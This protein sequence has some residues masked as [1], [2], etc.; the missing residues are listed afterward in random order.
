MP[1][2]SNTN[3]SLPPFCT[4]DKNLAEEVKTQKVLQRIM[5]CDVIYPKD[6]GAS[7]ELK[8]LLSRIFVADPAKRLSLPGIQQH[9]WFLKVCGNNSSCTPEERCL[10]AR[11]SCSFVMKH[12]TRDDLRSVPALHGCRCIK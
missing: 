4:Q 11:L 5:K 2:Q 8:D 6:I 12:C 10:L 7:P 9:P 1:C 3:G